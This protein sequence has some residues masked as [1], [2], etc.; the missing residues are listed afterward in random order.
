MTSH[1]CKVVYSEQ[2]K[3]DVRALLLRYL[4]KYQ[5]KP[6]RSQI[7]DAL[8]II[9]SSD[10]PLQYST[11]A[12]YFLDNMQ[13]LKETLK[14]SQLL[15]NHITINFVR[16]LKVV[17]TEKLKKRSGDFRTLFLNIYYKLMGSFHEFWDYFHVNMPNITVFASQA[18]EAQLERFFSLSRKVD[19]IYIGLLCNG[20]EEMVEKYIL[21]YQNN[22]ILILLALK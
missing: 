1:N 21:I 11:L 12:Q 3:E 16:T 9:C 13:G 15:F 19:K 5:D 14:D 4:D 17:I 2:F 10:F 8:R 7:N 6:S 20:Y 22:V 18:T